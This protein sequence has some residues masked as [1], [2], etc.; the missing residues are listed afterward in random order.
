M[1]IQG[2]APAV[3]PA[4]IVLPRDA[5][6]EAQMRVPH[7]EARG[8]QGSRY[9]RGPDGTGAEMTAMAKA[10]ENAT[11]AAFDAAEAAAGIRPLRGR[12]GSTASTFAATEC[13]AIEA[14]AAAGLAEALDEARAWGRREARQAALRNSRRR[15]RARWWNGE[16]AFR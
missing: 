12:P 5:F 9:D 6:A 7:R 1:S 15:H 8:R 10:A 16:Q 3:P 14:V 13:A 2:H 4:R 11:H